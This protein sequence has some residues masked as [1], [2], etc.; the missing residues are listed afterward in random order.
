MLKKL[1][2][3]GFK[4]FCDRTEVVLGSG[5]TAIVGPNGCGKSNLADAL[6]WVLGEQNPRVL[7]SA[8]LQDVIFGG[9]AGRKAMGMAEVKLL[10]DGM[11]GSGETEL[12]R[13]FAR[14]GSSEY[15]LNGKNVRWKD[16]I[17]TLLGTGLSHTGYVVIG[18]GT[19]HELVSGRP[20]DRKAWIEEASGVARVRIDKKET[21]TRLE[22]AKAGVSRVDDLIVEL[23]ARRERLSSDRELAAEY[24]RLSKE[25]RKTDLAMWLFQVEDQGKKAFSA[26]RRVEKFR[27]DL[28]SLELMLPKMT[29]ESEAAAKRIAELEEEGRRIQTQRESAASELF[30][31]EKRRDGARSEGLLLRKELE[32]RAVR[33]SGMEQDL[34]RLASEDEALAATYD[35]VSSQLEQVSSRHGEAVLAR[36]RSEASFKEQSEKV[37]LLRQETLALTSSLGQCQRARDEKRSRLAAKRSEGDAIRQWIATASAE[38]EKRSKELSSLLGESDDASRRVVEQKKL[39]EEHRSKALSTQ[40]ALDKATSLEK[41]TGARLSALRAR[42]KILSDL[43]KS[44]EGYG[45]GPR[46]VLEAKDAG[47]LTGIEGAVGGLLNCEARYIPALSAAIGG[48]AENIV[49]R[50]EGSAKLAIELL[51]STRSGRV[52]FLPVSLIRPRDMN[53]RALSLTGQMKGVQPL[54]NVVTFPPG[55]ERI[56]GYLVG[57]V[58][59]ADTMDVALAYMK[60]SGWATR[61]VTLSGESLEPGGAITGGDAP[62]HESIF[63]RRQ[64]L[65]DV[66]TQES[67][68]G[69]ELQEVLTRRRS[70]ERALA[71]CRAD[72]EK[73]RGDLALAESRAARLGEAKTRM[74]TLQKN[75]AQEIAEK[76]ASVGPVEVE[77]ATLASELEDAV[78]K[79][80][81]LAAEMESKMAELRD[82]EEQIRGGLARDEELSA[83]IRR[84]SEEKE[85]LERNVARVLRRREGLAGESA[86]LGRSLEEEL[87]QIERQTGLLRGSEDVEKDLSSRIER[88]DGEV[89]GMAASFAELS[90]HRES[91]SARALAITS[92]LERARRDRDS[93]CVKL[94]ET[95]EELGAL[96]DA[97]EETRDY[98][99][100]EFG[101]DDPDGVHHERIP[102]ATGL[103]KIEEIDSS[104]RA[105][106]SVNLKAEEEHSELT[107]RIDLINLERQDILDAIDEIN[108]TKEI[109]E[110][111]IQ[112]RFVDTFNLVAESFS[113][114]FKDLFGGGKGSLSL[115]E[116]S[117]GV[118]VSAEPPGR[119]QKH[120]NLLSG[121]ERSLCGIALIFAILSVRP[122]PLIVLDEVDTALDEANV[123]RFGQFLR[124]YS[125]DTQF[126]VITHQKA[127]MEAADL[128]YGVTMEEPGVSR[129]FGMRL[130]NE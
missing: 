77:I 97:Y 63:R 55:L 89:A 19:I 33:R 111:E 44:Y 79:E 81:L 20:E 62:R 5:I 9:T 116:E 27:Q 106:G 120:L 112:T 24:K 34:S 71:E 21:E 94:S 122:S 18:Q 58:V 7:R 49:V 68:L 3:H 128:L 39:L 46:S 45:R 84:L 14:D 69:V 12:L 100:S 53:P 109:V 29:D 121:G 124:R 113:E 26:R 92:D 37:L 80:T 64:E 126:L 17:E 54:L 129:V 83:E 47:R 40:T 8:R 59:L 35:E 67:A 6:R 107:D 73:A 108:K 102:R 76:K 48:S 93:L 66:L 23:S 38:Q 10:F 105:L 43:E 25:R 36:T 103:P 117:F 32:G 86:S 88:L 90:G 60:A 98:I 110:K 91:E 50:D 82:R 114:V 74:E 22:A 75:L 16:V 31:L 15:R 13:R 115:V 1:S 104:I 95:K 52:T 56:A 65:A 57:R 2:L 127:T 51:K 70:L 101:L 118:D 119:R 42:K 87:R 125:K 4:S 28:E 130:S 123:Q 99:A 78:A 85:N 11:N 61:V 72:L 30:S 41:N 96:S